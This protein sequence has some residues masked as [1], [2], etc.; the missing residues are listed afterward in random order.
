MMK[1]NNGKFK[2]LIFA[3]IHASGPEL[4]WT[5]RHIEKAT[6][7]ANPDLVVL[8]GDNLT[9]WFPGISV[10]KVKNAINTIG[11]IFQKRGI[12]F[13]FVYGNHDHEGLGSLGFDEMS[14]KRFI[15]NEFKKFSC[16]VVQ[17]GEDM[18]GLCNYNIPL[19]SSDGEK[20]KFNLW[21]MDSNPYAPENEGGGYGY[22]HN[23][24]I[25]WYEETGEK[26]K[27][28][29]NGKNVPSMLFQ[30]IIVPEI[31]D[32]LSC[33]DKRVNGSVKGQGKH[34]SHYYTANSEY[35]TSGTLREGPCPPDVK[36]E[37]FNSWLK[38]GDI[39][40]AFFGHDHINDF[41]GKYKGID[42]QQVPSAGFYSYGYAQGS[43]V[44]TLFEDDVEN[45]QT[46]V[47]TY[48]NVCDVKLRNHFIKKHG[49]HK[50]LTRY[51]PSLAGASVALTIAAVGVPL[52]MKYRKK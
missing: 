2:I 36:S 21:F 28:E 13:A 48:E 15:L 49:Y 47:I 9:G 8:L 1:F 29:N 4:K 44:V 32:M 16:C 35:I 46:E 30:H 18:T 10:I 31:Y 23:D 52:I 22:V 25:Q 20:V 43:R 17:Q 5:I 14:A 41:S 11:D 19:L 26:L 39:V 27:K 12:P 45:Y 40:A 34:S 24:Q 3:D 38:R 33:Y 37:Q 7:K 50:W 42:I 51:K 6:E